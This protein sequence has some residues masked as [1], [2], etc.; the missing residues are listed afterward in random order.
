[1]KHQTQINKIEWREVELGDN[2]YFEILSSGIDKFSSEKEYL[3]TESIK[4]T[5]IEK[6]EC[7]IKQDNKPSRANMQPSINSVWFA[8]MKGTLKVYSFTKDN[9]EEIDKY[10]LSTGFAGIKIKDNIFPDYIKFYFV[11]KKFN[12]EKDKLSTGSTQM[13]INNSFIM[14][15][16]ISLPFKDGKPDLKE[17]ERI[18]KILEEAE[19]IQDKGGN[20]GSLFDEYLKSVFNEM[21]F[22]KGFEKLKL[23]DKKIC[24]KITDGSHRTPKLLDKGYPFLTVANM[25]EFEFNYEGCKKISKE[26]F[27]DL[28]KND[29]QPLKGDVL[30]SKD[31]TVGKVMR[32]NKTKEQVIL[33]SIAIIRPKEESMNQIY[34]EY[35]LKESSSLNQ[36]V[37]R[38]SGSAIRRIILKQLKEIKIIV[39][40]LPLQEKFASIVK[41]VEELKE[42]VR[43][44]KQNSEELFNSLM[45]KAFRGEL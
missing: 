18:V 36:A 4:G 9:E 30:F 2:N 14:K 33:S 27:N 28:V 20:L 6:I 32:I 45:H 23:G 11:T 24:K 12:E 13:G 35:V 21:F 1:M 19:K 43:K 8:K 16:K 38:K 37:T 39:P 26:D 31:G 41:H 40:P 15:I 29:C 25:G 42:N 22:D 10:I 3:S 5:K 7:K 17:Q 44:T 34:L